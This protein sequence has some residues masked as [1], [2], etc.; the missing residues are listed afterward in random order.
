MKNYNNNITNYMPN[1]IQ[2]NMQNIPNNLPNNMPNNFMNN[3]INNFQG[4]G[5]NNSNMNNY[6]QQQNNSFQKYNALV[7][8][9]IKCLE[10]ENNVNHE[11]YVTFKQNYENKGNNP[12]LQGQNTFTTSIKEQTSDPNVEKVYTIEFTSKIN[13]EYVDLDKI[14]SGEEKKTSV[15]VFG[16]NLPSK[17]GDFI[18]KT[19]EN[20]KMGLEDGQAVYDMIYIPKK[21]DNSDKKYFVINFRKSAYIINFDEAMKDFMKKNGGNK[22]YLCWFK[23]QGDEMKSFL[24]KR[25]QKKKKDFIQFL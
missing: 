15:S 13:Y 16:T 1:N 17:G 8:K 20:F 6:H 2:N 14:S 23:R 4:M 10:D 7:A 18:L 9:A 25:Q 5:N 24:Q 12:Q 22:Y 11:L 21:K 19:L 3:G